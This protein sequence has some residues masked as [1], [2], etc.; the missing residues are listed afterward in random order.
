MLKPYVRHCGDHRRAA[1]E[2]AD[3][4]LLDYLLV[5]IADGQGRFRIAGVSYDVVPGDLYWIPPGVTHSMEG[6]APSM[7]CPY[8]HFDLLYRPMVSHWE[9]DVPGGTLDL[10]SFGE[11]IHPEFTHP[12]LDGLTGRIQGYNN[13]RVGQIIRD[14]VAEQGRAQPFSELRLSGLVLEMIAEI[15]RGREGLLG[16]Y[17]EHVPSLESV[18]NYV[19]INCWRGITVD[20]LSDLCEL[21]PS[22]F[23]LLFGRHF[24]CPPRTYLRRARIMRA[25]E[26]MVGSAVNFSEIARR[27]GFANLHSFSRAFRAVEGISPSDYRKAGARRLLSS[28]T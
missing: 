16:L 2:I 8:V 27:C 7:D 25:K 21:S 13:A 9:W 3:R 23:R 12:M 19:R 20:D 4:K 1:W 18:A 17:G 14:I 24:G 15:L 11:R 6:F 5:Y 10:S 28:S 26:M 22:H